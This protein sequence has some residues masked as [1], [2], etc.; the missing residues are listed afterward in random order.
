MRALEEHE[1]T[2]H[3]ERRHFLRRNHHNFE[4]KLEN[5]ISIISYEEVNIFMDPDKD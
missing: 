5:E 2:Y 1:F 3:E 4:I